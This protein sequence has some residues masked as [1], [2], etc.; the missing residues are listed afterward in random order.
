VLGHEA[1]KKGQ[2]ATA[3]RCEE[4]IG[5]ELSMFVERVWTWSGRLEDLEPEQLDNLIADL[6]ARIAA[7]EAQKQLTGPV[8]DI[9]GN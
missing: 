4:L 5:K 3:V 2:Y 9:T 1:Q 7:A 6:D 8:V